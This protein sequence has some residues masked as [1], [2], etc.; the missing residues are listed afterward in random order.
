MIAEPLSAIENL[1]G[2]GVR[3]DEHRACGRQC[4]FLREVRGNLGLSIERRADGGNARAT[5]CSLQ[6]HYKNVADEDGSAMNF[7]NSF[8][9]NEPP[10]VVPVVIAGHRNKPVAATGCE[11]FEVVGTSGRLK[12]GYVIAS[13]DNEIRL[14][15]Q[16]SEVL[17][18][19]V[20]GLTADVGHREN[21]QLVRLS[22]GGQLR[23][24]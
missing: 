21:A 5:R 17:E 13:V 3:H 20:K 2:R 18:K 14:A 11:C 16:L 6:S 15:G 24:G 23:K 1:V 12:A 9:V 8:A 10:G 4:Q 19:I 22:S 7:V